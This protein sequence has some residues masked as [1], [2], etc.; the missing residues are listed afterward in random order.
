MVQTRQSVNVKTNKFDVH[1]EPLALILERL[2]SMIHNAPLVAIQSFSRTGEILYW[3]NASQELYGYSAAQVVGRRVKDLLLPLSDVREFV[4]LVEKLGDQPR[5]T[6]T[7]KWQCKTPSGIKKWIQSVFFPIFEEETLQKLFRVDIDISEHVLAEQEVLRSQNHYKTLLETIPDGILEVTNDA[8]I[9]YANP[10]MHNLLGYHDGELVGNSVDIIFA[11]QQI[12]NSFISKWPYISSGQLLPMPHEIDLVKRSGEKL[13]SLI[14]WNYKRDEQNNVQGFIAVVT[15]ISARKRTE[16]E[17]LEL[18]MQLEKR[19]AQRTAKLTQ[20]HQ[21]LLRQIEE[22]T[23]AEK[24]L[25]LERNLLQSLIDNL[26]N[27]IYLKDNKGAFI[28]GNKSMTSFLQEKLPGD[29][30]TI[31]Q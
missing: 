29:P 2:R 26:P 19:V 11:D 21:Q 24:A 14:H 15:D 16:R 8:S 5:S 3:N 20:A 30:V 23:A 31:T 4:S 9:L 13:E 6:F 22:K 12:K 1:N 17:L 25:E 27:D 18:N 10:A 28:F 7:D